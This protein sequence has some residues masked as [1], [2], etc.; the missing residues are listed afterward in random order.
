VFLDPPFHE[1]RLPDCIRL[2]EA[3]TW[4]AGE[5]WIYIEAERGLKL[6]LPSCWDVYR[7]KRAGNVDYYL[8]RRMVAA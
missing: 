5:A 4:L 3:G 7:S 2:L 6:E 8:I 1:N